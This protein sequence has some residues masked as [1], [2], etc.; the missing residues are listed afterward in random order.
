MNHHVAKPIRSTFCF[1]VLLQAIG[2][3]GTTA[4]AQGPTPAAERSYTQTL[5]LQFASPADAQAAELEITPVPDG[6]DWAVSARWDDSRK[7]NVQMARLMEKHGWPGTFFLNAT[8]TKENWI[9]QDYVQ[10]LL[11]TGSDIGGHSQTHDVLTALKPNEMFYDILANRIE[12]EDQADRPLNTF[13]FPFGRFESAGDPRVQQA[14]ILA[15]LA[16][17]YH[18]SVYDKFVTDSPTLENGEVSVSLA[19]RPG[20]RDVDEKRYTKLID[21]MMANRQALQVD[22]HCF[23]IGIHVSYRDQGWND[24][25]QVLSKY[26]HREDWWYGTLTQ[27]AAY[28]L[29]RSRATLEKT[30]VNGNTATWRI[31]RPVPAVLGAVIPMTVSVQGGDLQQ[32]A[33]FDGSCDRLDPS[34]RTLLNLGPP[35]G[36]PIPTTVQAFDNQDNRPAPATQQNPSTVLSGHLY[37]NEAQQALTLTLTNVSGT[38]LDHIDLTWRLPPMYATNVASG[39]VDSL[40]ASESIEVTYPLGENRPEDFLSEGEPY[41]AVECDIPHGGRLDRVWATTR[42]AASGSP[43]KVGDTGQMLGPLPASDPTPLSV[44]DLSKPDTPIVDLGD[45]PWMKWFT[46]NQADRRRYTGDRVML[47]QDD[48]GWNKRMSST[49]NQPRDF[50]VA[51]NFDLS[52]ASDLQLDSELQVTEVFLNGDTPDPQSLRGKA[53]VNRM[54]LRLH[55]KDDRSGFKPYPAFL[56]LIP[57][58]GT[59]TYVGPTAAS[60]APPLQPVASSPPQAPNESVELLPS[61]SHARLRSQGDAATIS[62]LDGVCAV[63]VH[64]AG[65]WYN[66][67]LTITPTGRWKAGDTLALQIEARATQAQ[68]ESGEGWLLMAMQQSQAPYAKALRREQSIP[69]QWTTLQYPFTVSGAFNPGQSEVILGLGNRAQRMEVRRISLKNYGDTPIADIPATQVTYAGR[70][71]DAPWRAEAAKRIDRLRKATLTVKVVNDQGRVVPDA[72]V[73]I[74]QTRHAFP[75]GSAVAADLL[76]A[77]SPDAQRYQAIVEQNFNRVVL[78][79]N[80]KWGPW[81]EHRE[82]AIKA[83]QWLNERGIDARG[84]V[85]VWPSFKKMYQAEQYANSPESLSQYIRDHIVDEVTG[86]GKLVAQWDVLN[87]PYNNHDAM[88]L[89]GE[90]VMV[91]WFK[92]AREHN[93]QAELFIND[94]GILSGGGAD[95]AHQDHYEKTIRYLLQHGAPLDGIGL[96]GHFLSTLTPP[97]RLISLLDR[98]GALGPKLTITELDVDAPSPDLQADYLRDFLTV[99]FSHPQV[100]GVLM[101][102][103]WEGRHWRPNAALYNRDWSTRPAGDAW[104]KLIFNDWWSQADLVTDASGQAS[105]RVFKGDYQIQVQTASGQLTQQ[106]AIPNQDVSLTVKIAP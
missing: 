68:D 15:F 86:V 98:F 56:K 20:D 30:G 69:Q 52:E 43:L 32:V 67:Q 50:L 85:L 16:T 27:Y 13:A 55:T 41:F 78:E 79:N 99:C 22:T 91:D 35:A 8:G 88:D 11:A 72:Q 5:R 94:F 58:Q 77:D 33:A 51:I 9:G 37:C 101:W 3:I 7:D 61:L 104:Q 4:W 59:L 60:A 19:T 65:Q 14:M 39:R 83:L 97:D 90:Q 92:L 63:D 53:G 21:S 73:K 44:A 74:R 47:Y 96:Q 25:E 46:A 26:A 95:T 6:K 80:L 28:A 62:V 89:I 106:V 102:G 17:G 45:D 48:K 18:H 10:S 64:E 38:T 93:D 57:R 12:K 100:D 40:G 75:F 2:L 34:G 70:E 42:L 87:E 31:T 24:I 23:Y 49:V 84:H 29:Q 66:A 36:Q 71:P 82:R 105:S 81:V 1:A 76:L 54:I 103:F